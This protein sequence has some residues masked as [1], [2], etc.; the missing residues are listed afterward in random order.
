MLIGIKLFMGLMLIVFGYLCLTIY[1][2]LEKTR[3]WFMSKTT[4][5]IAIPVEIQSLISQAT[6]PF[7]DGWVQEGAR[8]QLEHIR[9]IIDEALEKTK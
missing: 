5:Q 9:N 4:E 2:R 3:R 1:E 7:N 6:S 8:K